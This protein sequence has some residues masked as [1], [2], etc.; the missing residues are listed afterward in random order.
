MMPGRLTLLCIAL[1][2]IA[3]CSS[4]DPE[5]LVPEQKDGPQMAK[6]EAVSGG[7]APGAGQQAT[8]TE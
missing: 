7:G 6:P 3:G 1:C 5:S 8:A 2:V 4:E